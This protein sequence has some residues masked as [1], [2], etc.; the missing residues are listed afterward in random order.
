[1]LPLQGNIALSIS[2]REPFE[3]GRFIFFLV[4]ILGGVWGDDN[5]QK[6][7]LDVVELFAIIWTQM[8][9]NTE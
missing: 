4:P 6:Y 7:K 2:F 8:L 1:M 5:V 9:L 3:E